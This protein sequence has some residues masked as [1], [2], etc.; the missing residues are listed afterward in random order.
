MAASTIKGVA[1]L[2]VAADV[3]RLRKSGVIS[4]ADLQTAIKSD[5]LKY[6]DEPVVPGLW[7]PLGT[8]G[9]LLELLCRKEGG[10]RA[11]YLIERGARAAERMMSQGA[12]REFLATANRWGE[13]A[14]QAMVQLAKALYGGTRWSASYSGEEHTAE[15][16][17]DDARDFPIAARYAAQGFVQVLFARIEGAEVAV[18]SH[19][20]KP[21]RIVYSIRRS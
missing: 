21:D 14:G 6:L 17:V 9:R 12:Y 2:S 19:S 15:I 10:D 5:E 13:R 8:Y 16:V 3:I 7:Y 18:S 4:E 11:E 1:F 20:P